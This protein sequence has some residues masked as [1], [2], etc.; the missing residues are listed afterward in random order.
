VEQLL[1]NFHALNDY[2][3]VMI[4]VGLGYL[5][6]VTFLLSSCTISGD[7]MLDENDNGR[8]IQLSQDEDFIITLASNPSTGFSW[9][10]AEID[11]SI[12]RQ[13]GESEYVISDQPNQPIPGEGGKEV[14]RFVTVSPGKT[15]LSLF[16]TRPWEE[17]DE[18][19]K[20]FSIE[21]SV[22]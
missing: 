11:E 13:V 18:P 17:T 19:E 22:Q 20:S 21:V 5:L 15:T 16:Y 9:Q 8:K 10:V 14:F 7:I 4:R 1:M 6:L 2:F 12:L 3:K